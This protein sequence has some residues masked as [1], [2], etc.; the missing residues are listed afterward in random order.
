MK[1]L[2]VSTGEPFLQRAQA[3]PAND[4]EYVVADE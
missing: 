4:A 1:R 3:S 2:H